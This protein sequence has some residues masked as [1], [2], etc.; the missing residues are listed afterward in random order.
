MN[1]QVNPFQQFILYT[2]D[3]GDVKLAV[4]L[5]NETIW[6]TQKMIAEL[7]TVDRTVVSKHLKNIFETEELKE[8]AVSAIIAHTAED[9]KNYKTRFYNLDAIIA[10][11]YR[12][13]SKRAT[14][15]R[16]W[17][18]QVIREYI[19]KGFA[20]DD[21]RLKQAETV[22]GKDY[23]RQ[24]LERIRS[25]RT[26]ERRI[27]MQ[28]TD[29]FAECSIDY[30]PQSE[31]T[32]T[33]FA[34]VQNKFHYA[35]TG[36]TAPEIIQALADAKKPN[37]GLTT[38]RNGPAGRILKSDVS[39]AKN[40]LSET[41]IKKLERTISSFFDY[42]ETVIERHTTFTMAQFAESV[43]KFLTFNEYKIL[44]NAGSISHAQATRKAEAEYNIFN[45]TQKID[46]DF[47]RE[48]K[49]LLKQSDSPS[50]GD[51]L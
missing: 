14:Q 19:I 9:G 33:F 48:V 50:P 35:I 43:N 15:F 23:F 10:V 42:I 17:A 12:V 29:I 25:I 4:F 47:E 31:V 16:I 37:M 46:S 49:K 36:K 13:S 45:R 38:W 6:L 2:S 26:S 39:I 34:T 5:R 18:T 11:G 7:F 22:F 3:T 24:L 1:N 8:D 28:I 44:D 32:K 21:D 20:L 41:E 51:E 30:D 27:Y 40:Y